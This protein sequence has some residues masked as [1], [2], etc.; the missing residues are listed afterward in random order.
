MSRLAGLGGSFVMK[1]EQVSNTMTWVRHKGVD[2][3][4]RLRTD[5]LWEARFKGRWVM[6]PS[7]EEAIAKV[8]LV[9]Q[10][11]NRQASTSS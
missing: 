7:K 4:V 5:G 3:Y 1:I 6:A 2:A 9:I 10:E 11:I 8:E